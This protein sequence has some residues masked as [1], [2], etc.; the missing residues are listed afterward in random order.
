[1]AK[2]EANSIIPSS[3]E[4]GQ[5]TSSRKVILDASMMALPSVY[6]VPP[7]LP[8]IVPASFL[9]DSLMFTLSADGRLACVRMHDHGIDHS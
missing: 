6:G 9:N 7:I 5:P 8:F 4:V 3:D 1:M 2:P